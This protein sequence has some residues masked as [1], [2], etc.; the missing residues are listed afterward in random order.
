MACRGYVYIHKLGSGEYEAIGYDWRGFIITAPVYS[1]NYK[2]AYN[3]IYNKL[4]K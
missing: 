3:K 1:K 2:T 4:R